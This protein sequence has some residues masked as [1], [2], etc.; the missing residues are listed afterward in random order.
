MTRHIGRASVGL[1]TATLVGL[2]ASACTGG[3][4]DA[5]RSAAAAPATTATQEA[6]AAEPA[7]AV[8]E[9]QPGKA[10]VIFGKDT[11]RAEI[12]RTDTARALGLMYRDSV[13]AGTGMLFVFSK[14]GPQSFWMENTYVPLDIAFMNASYAVVDIQ[15]MAPLTTTPHQSAAPAMFALEVHEG[16][17]EKHGVRVGSVPKVVFGPQIT[18]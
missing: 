18:G 5:S 6:S 1:L 17:F 4:A 10:W 12:A 9:P 2:A 3:H 16:W 14:M 11:V 8:N 7:A 15:H 13:P